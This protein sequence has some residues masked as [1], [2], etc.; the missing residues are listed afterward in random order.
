MA[1]GGVTGKD[2]RAA[3]EQMRP[4][5]EVLVPMKRLLAIAVARD[6]DGDVQMSDVLRDV[7]AASDEKEQ[8][9]AQLVDIAANLVV[10]ANPSEHVR[11]R[12][13]LSA[14]EAERQKLL[15]ENEAHADTID[16]LKASLGSMATDTIAQD[17]ADAYKHIA[18]AA[19]EALGKTLITMTKVGELLHAKPPPIP[20][21]ENGASGGVFRSV[22]CHAQHAVDTCTAASARLASRIATSSEVMTNLGEQ[23]AALDTPAT[24]SVE[25]AKKRRKTAAT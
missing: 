9:L 24:P 3:I 21:D 20:A 12:R 14:C 15:K 23:L 7:V 18:T 1:A 5:S 16:T 17:R 8:T 10:G 13:A 19:T 6:K 11:L 22:L 4:S 25:P 2:M